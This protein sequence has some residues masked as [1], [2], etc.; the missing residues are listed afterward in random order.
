M[1][2]SIEARLPFLDHRLV[3]FTALLPIQQKISNGVTKFVLR[4]AIARIVPE[5][6]RLR[7]DKMGFVTPE[8][9]WMKTILRGAI[10]KIFS[11]EDFGRT[12][13]FHQANLLKKVQKY[14]QTSVG[15]SLTRS[16]LW[17][18]LNLYLWL[19]VFRAGKSRFEPITLTA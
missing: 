11:S 3:E 19:K 14:S 2:F 15:D 5:E 8:E 4:N 17:R 18:A 7:A 16:E 1:A 9:M 12:G 13:Y 10:E 6:V